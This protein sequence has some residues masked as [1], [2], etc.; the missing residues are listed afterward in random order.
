MVEKNG[1]LAYRTL[2]SKFLFNCCWCRR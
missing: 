2:F 1:G